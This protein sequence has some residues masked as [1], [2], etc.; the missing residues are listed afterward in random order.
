LIALSKIRAGSLLALIIASLSLVGADQAPVI[1][2]APA[3]NLELVDV[4]LIDQAERKI[5]MAAY[6]LTDW[7]VMA[8]LIRAARRGVK[9]R[10]YMDGK[11]TGEQDPS[12]S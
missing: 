8:A 11:R 3:E 2:Y 9:V 7:P 6:V 1:H 12:G 4:G 5:D 10:I